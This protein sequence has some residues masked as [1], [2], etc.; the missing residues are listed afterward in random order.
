MT[1]E[2]KGRVVLEGKVT[3]EAVVSRS[4]FNSLASYRSA[5]MKKP[6]KM[7]CSDQDNA[8]LFDKVI[9]DKI[10]CLPQTIGSTTGGLVIQTIIDM[11]LAPRAFLF[12]E[13]IDS[14]AASGIILADI[15][16]GKRIITID[17][18]G[19]EFLQ[20]VKEGQ[21]IEIKK[22]GTVVLS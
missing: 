1:K 21:K 3:G 6:K 16:M 5:A 14:L 20:S 18:L 9:S 17:Q 19:E 12:S 15:W 4:G 13:H 8:D 22:D 2:F 11:D 7:I 10:L